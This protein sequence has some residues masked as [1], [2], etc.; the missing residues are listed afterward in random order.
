[1]RGAS[2]S[3]GTLR[4][5]DYGIHNRVSQSNALFDKAT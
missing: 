4:Q 1:M 2:A 5:K 3:Y